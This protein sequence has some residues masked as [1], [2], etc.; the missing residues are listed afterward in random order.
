[1]ELWVSHVYVALCVHAYQ[2]PILLPVIS[3]TGIEF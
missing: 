3:L 2:E 1:M